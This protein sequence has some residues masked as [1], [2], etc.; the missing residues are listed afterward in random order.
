MSTGRRM[1]VM[2]RGIVV[3]AP[4]TFADALAQEIKGYGA[5]IRKD[6]SRQINRLRKGTIVRSEA[7]LRRRVKNLRRRRR[8]YSTEEVS[9]A[10]GEIWVPHLRQA[11]EQ[12]SSFLSGFMGIKCYKI[13][14]QEEEAGS[15]L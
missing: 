1:R 4:I 3:R 14:S 13:P 10:L 5:E 2:R 15:G 12:P 8:S 7:A 6:L 9:K 11:I